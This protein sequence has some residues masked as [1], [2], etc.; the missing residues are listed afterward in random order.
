MNKKLTPFILLTSALLL[1]G[2]KATAQVTIGGSVYGGGNYAPVTGSASVTIE[3]DGATVNGNVYGGGNNITLD[4][5]T[6]YGV[7]ASD[8]E[9]T[10][11]TVLG[12]VSGV[13][14]GVYGGCNVKGTVIG[15]SE[16]KIYGGTI[17]CQDSLNNFKTVDVFGGGLGEQTSV[18]GDV[19]VTVNKTGSVAPTIYGDVY[20]G[21]ALGQVNDEPSDKTTVNILEGTLHSV[22]ET[23]TGGF[24]IYHG[25]NVYGGGLG[26]TGSENVTK[27][28][29]NGVVTVNIGTGTVETSGDYAGYTNTP[30]TGNA[31]IG[32]NVY[33]CNNTNGSPQEDVTV[34]I[35]KT[36]HVSGINTIDDEG[37][38]IANVFG[39]GNQANYL[40]NKYANVNIYACDNTIER[41]FGGGNAAATN[42]VNTMI[43]GGRFAQVF[44]G[45]NGEVTAANVTGNINLGIH[46]GYVGQFYGASNQN[47]NI[48]GTISVVVDNDG[49]CEDE[50]EI[51]ELFCGGNFA[52]ITGDL[53]TDI[54]CS[55]GDM[56][57]NN[58]YGGCNQANISGHV[59]LNV[60]GGIYDNVF[61]GSKGTSTTAANIGGD[62]T[63]NLYGGTIGNAFGGSNVNGNIEGII[64]VNVLD[65]EGDCPLNV[66]NIYGGSNLTSYT[67]TGTVTSPV[68]NVVHIKNGVSGNVYGGS[69]GEEGTT[70]NV[71]ANPLVNIGYN[72]DMNGFITPTSTYLTDH[73][74]LLTAPRAIIAGSVFGGGDAAV[75]NGDTEILLRNRAKVF[76][77]VYGGGNM[78]EVNGNTKVI[79]NGANN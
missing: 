58:L 45:G 38:A 75:V 11:G 44:G 64:T 57:I 43:Q 37:Y 23:I 68:V 15:D 59:V 47:G 63:L 2:T 66:T 60:Y 61:G 73:A 71:N 31:T 13:H 9:M 29:V 33:G 77:N 65:I 22:E 3:Q 32:G 69:K 26:Q 20:G 67:P 53:E 51:N 10:A 48:T 12:N 35:F 24:K 42:D 16:V 72:A 54:A 55:E 17:G 46:G 25:G 74:A 70:T 78:G 49:P 76:G 40:V 28:Q 52:N 50:L 27:G 34:N 21:S 39:G 1:I 36:A 4:G 62:V 79:V 7:N 18:K 41:V 5:A 30:N 56:K 8:V 14:G 19:T 6:P